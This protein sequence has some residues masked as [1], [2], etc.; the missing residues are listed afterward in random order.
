MLRLV[1]YSF[2]SKKLLC[3][4]K[5]LYDE[6]YQVMSNNFILEENDSSTL[7]RTLWLRPVNPVGEPPASGYR[8]LILSG[9]RQYV[10]ESEGV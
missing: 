10:Y 6:G 2:F 9:A 3:I 1:G 4:D 5:T 8:M 7:G